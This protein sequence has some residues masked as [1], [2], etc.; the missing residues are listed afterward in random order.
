MRKAWLALMGAAERAYRDAGGHKNDDNPADPYMTRA[1][2]L[3]Q[4][5]R[6][7]R[8]AAHP[9]GGGPEHAQGLRRRASGSARRAGSSRT[10]RPSPRSSSSPRAC[11]TDKVAEARA[12]ARARRSTRRRAR[13]LRDRD[14]HD[15]GR[16][17][18]PAAR[19]DGRA[20][21]AEDA[22]RVHPG[23]E[24]RRPRR[25]AARARRHAAQ[26]PQAA[27]PL[28]L[29]ALPPLPRDL[30][31]LGRGRQRHAVLGARARP[32]LRRRARGAG[33]PRSSPS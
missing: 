9:R 5:A 32:R 2:L 14:Q 22:R 8:R 13:R 31:P 30:L 16:P 20:R 26:H 1:R 24:P 15:L 4:P 29:R 19:A 11:R 6:A 25:R 3:Q 7:R 21:P 10:A 12:A 17:R 33:A 28:A 18:H 27:R 23:D